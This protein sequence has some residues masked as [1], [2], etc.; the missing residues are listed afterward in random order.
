MV[1]PV[2]A[3]LL[4]KP[5][6][7]RLPFTMLRFLYDGQV[8]T[9]SRRKLRDLLILLLRCATI[10]LIA[11]LFARPM[12]HIKRKPQKSRTVYCLGLDNSMSMAY[13]DGSGSYFDTLKESAIDYIRS[14]KPDTLFNICVLAS[15]NWSQDLSKEQALTEIKGLK[16]EH[17]NINVSN[18]ISCLDRVKRT[19][20]FDDEVSVL[21]LSDFTPN[22]IKQFVD[23]EKPALVNKIDYKL[24]VS[25]EPVNNAAIVD[26]HVVDIIDGKLTLNVTVANYGR[27]EQNRRIT[28]NTGLD[29]SAPIE[30]NLFAQQRRTFQIQIRVNTAGQNQFFLPVE[31]SLSDGDG[32]KED[33]TFYLAVSCPGQKNVKVLLAGNNTDEMFLLKTAIDTISRNRSYDT[34]QIKEVLFDDITPLDFQWADIFVCSGVT[35]K[36][37][38]LSSNIEGFI[39]AGGRFVCFVKESVDAQAARQLWQRDILAALPGKCIHGRIYMQPNPS[40]SRADG[41]DNI[42]ARSLSNYRI[43]KIL[44]KGY[45]NCQPHPDSKCLWQFQNGLGCIYLKHLGIGFSILVNTSVDDSLGTLTK[46]NASVAFYQYLLGKDNQIGEYCFTRNEQVMLPLSEKQA[47]FAGRKEFWIQTC[48]GVKH[49]ASAVDSYLLITDPAGI[50]WVKTLNKPTMWAGVNLPKGETDMTKPVAS[51]LA[52]II[53]RVFPT[54]IDRGLSTAEIITD[55]KIEPVWKYVAWTLIILLLVEPTVANRLKR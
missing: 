19:E 47:A 31:L 28:A 25:P 23:T 8:E 33:D 30:V 46:S 55:K 50:G 15:G 40:A 49:R 12:L 29:K 32:L 21:V 16:I 6:F 24:I 34:L 54:E 20:Y 4:A 11:I 18:F 35:G 5:R 1:G 10:I 17:N 3:H 44:F 48:D 2:V 45:L 22:I 9:R 36:L 13:N 52:N 41:V 53:N 26:A 14:A 38:Y 42:A 39:N 7:R 51:E 43:D 37:A 27:V